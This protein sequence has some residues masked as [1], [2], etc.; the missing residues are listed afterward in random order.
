[1]FTK[2]DLKK[3]LHVEDGD[4]VEVVDMKFQYE[5]EPGQPYEVIVQRMHQMLDRRF[6]QMFAAELRL[7]P[8][9][10]EEGERWHQMGLFD[11][12]LQVIADQARKLHEMGATFGPL[13]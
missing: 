12:P 3:Q 10:I 7:M 13:N 9:R 6:N 8:G 2:S 1:M 4:I 11:D 5:I